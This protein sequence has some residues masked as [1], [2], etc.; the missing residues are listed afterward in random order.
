[1][2]LFVSYAR[3]DTP[4]CKPIVEALNPVHEVWYD[5]RL[6]AG[7]DWWD[8]IQRRL[9]WCQGFVYLLSPES[10]ASEYCRKEYN[11]ARQN[12]K[13][14]FPVLI[15][16]K[17]DVPDDLL[18]WQVCDLSGG[19]EQI[20]HLLN[21]L[22]V[23]ERQQWQAPAPVATV[24]ESQPPEADS[25]AMPILE[26]AG[27]A[28]DAQD[29]DRAVYL[30]KELQSRKLPRFMARQL[31]PMLKEAEAAL[32]R[33]AYLRL[34]E[35]EYAPIAT[36]IQNASMRQWGCEALQEFLVEFP[37]YDP[38]NLVDVCAEAARQP[39]I[40]VIEPSVEQART[41]EV[42]DI[43]PPP[44]EWCQI[45]AGKV[46]LEDASH[47]DPPGTKG[48]IYRV[49]GF[50][51]AKYP[52][53]N[54]QYQVF[55]DADDGYIEPRWWDFSEHA[56]QW[57][58]GHPAPQKSEWTGADLPRTNITWYEALAFC[59]WL[60]HRTG[61][62]ITLPTEQQWQR[63]AQGDDGRQYPWGDEFDEKRCNAKESDI[64]RT[65]PVTQYPNGASPYGVLDMSGNVWEWCLTAWGEDKVNINGNSHRVLRGGSWDDFADFVRAPDRLRYDPDFG[66][67]D[68]G[69]RC[70]RSY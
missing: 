27:H 35:Y 42:S 40:E 32:E 56:R 70:A 34:A 21:G 16:A 12:G 67:L 63:A 43:L 59:R 31:K 44:F 18:R 26:T 46:T 62:D 4:L 2:K 50:F 11:I 68:I 19:L 39:R 23:A 47:Y 9:H 57:R 48:G 5:N 8:A 37:D 61:Q 29:Y 54:A 28:M 45:P 30:L 6:F 25:E 55:V 20:H 51:I 64:G 24:D 1:M 7:Q 66:D 10:V 52:I 53:T 22:V 14:I 36:M 41:V 49:E 33:Q 13:K 3:V 17:T 58:E 69:L 65:T 15:Q 38:Q 60:S